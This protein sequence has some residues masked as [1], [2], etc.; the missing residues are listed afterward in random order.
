MGVTDLRH[1]EVSYRDFKGHVRSGPLVVHETVA[2]DVLW[3]FHRLFRAD[4]RIHPIKMP[5]AFRPPTPADY[6]NSTRNRTAGF[7]CR[8]ATGNPGS[9]SHHSY[10]WAIDINPLQN[11]YVT[12]AGS[13]S[14]APR[15]RTST[16]RW[17]SQA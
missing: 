6:W 13:C 17:A 3:V 10:G 4:F 1:V 16:A 14:G 2:R 11:P 8:P 12:S 15:S 5:P 9:L 7:N